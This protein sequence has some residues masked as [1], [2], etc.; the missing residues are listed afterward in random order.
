MNDSNPLIKY[1]FTLRLVHWVSAFMIIFL[2]V[3]GIYMAE[4]D[5]NTAN[6]YDFYPIHQSL[7]VLV[8]AL[9]LIRIIVRKKSKIPA[10]VTGL[11]PW[12]LMAS[13]WAHRS[14][15]LCML[16]MPLSGYLMTSTYAYSEGVDMFG[17][18]TIP[19]MTPKNELWSGIFH[20]IHSLTSWL[21]LIILLAHVFGVIK[22]KLF[23]TKDKNVLPR[24]L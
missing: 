6:K 1:P 16:L 20:Q 18:F 14:L 19:D 13:K 4:L 15:Y 9:V 24:M 17:L 12:E 22:H 3:V 8:M 11:K 7:G 2:L 10:P 5:P 21:L 23:D